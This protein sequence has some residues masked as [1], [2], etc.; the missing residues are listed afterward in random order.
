MINATRLRRSS[1]AASGLNL[2][3]VLRGIAALIH[4]FLLSGYNFVLRP[5]STTV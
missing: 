3:G 1:A 4:A 5:S 2:V